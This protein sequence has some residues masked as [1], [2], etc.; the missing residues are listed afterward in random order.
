MTRTTTP[1]GVGH[2]SLGRAVL[3]GAIAGVIASVVMAMYAMIAADAKD[4]GFFT[5]LYHIASLV[6]NDSNMMKSMKADQ[7][8]GDAFTFLFG[9]A[10]L[11]AM[12]HM[13][14]GAMY[15]AVFGVIASRLRLGLTALA[16]VGV[17]YGFLVFVM[18]AYIGLPLAAAIFNSGD[19][20]KNMAEMAGW[21]TFIVEHL[22][23]GVALGALTALGLARYSSHRATR[24]VA[25]QH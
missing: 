24:A 18:S 7:M 9:P 1:S 12:I 17:V 2:S 14:T 8:N 23:Y 3:I 10:V 5:P 6:T 13:M 20:I 4:T 11:G 16:G 22:L 15:G 21:G 25:A 19:P